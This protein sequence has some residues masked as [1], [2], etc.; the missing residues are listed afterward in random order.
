MPLP[1][2]DP[3][4]AQAVRVIKSTYGDSVSIEDKKKNLGKFGSNAA[5]GTSFETI[6]QFQGTTANETFV[7]TN[8]IDS[9]VSSSG[10]DVS[11]TIV[12]E[13]H[14]A[15]GSGNLT[16]VSQEKTLVGQSEAT[17]TT[18]L[19]RCNR[20]YVKQTGTALSF[21]T[22]LVGTVYCYDNTDGITSGVP[23]TAAATKCLILPGETQS[24]KC[25]TSISSTDYWIITETSIG[26][27]AV[28]GGGGSSER[29]EARIE[30]RDV[31]NGGAWRP[32]SASIGLT[33]GSNTFI[34]NLNP[35]LIVPKNHDV[36][37]RA[38]SDSSTCSISGEISG[39]LASVVS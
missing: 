10:S 19:A 24:Q 20:L 25:A 23:D 18:P 1:I 7:T 5:V 4:I 27:T 11:Q 16:F 3:N 21:P 17:L 35:Y 30:S 39:I 26:V 28:T 14:T 22:A 34:E 2:Q 31:A 37:L 8:L 13:G 29:V 9:I 32:V 38:K 12:I 33:V 6:A 15:D 36:R